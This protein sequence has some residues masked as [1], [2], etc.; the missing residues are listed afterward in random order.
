[1]SKFNKTTA[2]I[3][4]VLFGWC[5]GYHFYM[6]NSKKAGTSLLFFWTFIP[7]FL[8]LFHILHI[9][10]TSPEELERVLRCNE[11]LLEAEMKQAKQQAKDNIS[12]KPFSIQDPK[13]IL[14]NVTGEYQINYRDSDG[15]VSTRMITAHKIKQYS[16]G[17]YDYI[18]AYCHT[19]QQP[20]TFRSD[21]IIEAVDT[22][23][24]EILTSERLIQA[25]LAT[26][27]KTGVGS[28]EHTR[29][30]IGSGII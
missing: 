22:R 14:T 18:E 19:K 9:I 28:E 5:G 27:P 8:S 20:R 25:M 23:T 3:V 4:T 12:E 26:S 13:P 6:K 11:A 2:I 7:A 1:M 21:C 16:G 24:G 29:R 15:D 10:I 30:L 17:K